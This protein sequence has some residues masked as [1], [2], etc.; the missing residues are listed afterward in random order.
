MGPGGV[1]PEPTGVLG[2]PAGTGRRP[3]PGPAGAALAA[4]ASLGD[5][6]HAAG[7][8]DAAQMSRTFLRMFG[9]SPSEVRRRSGL[10]ARGG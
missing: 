4:G 6:A 2:V 7:F 8:A 9:V 5:A 1:R 3:G 10:S